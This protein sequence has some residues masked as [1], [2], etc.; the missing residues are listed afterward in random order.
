MDCIFCRII[1][2]EIPATVVYRD[3]DV[4]AFNDISPAAP[5]HVLI[6]P[7]K[8]IPRIS[9]IEDADA[10]L[11]GKMHLVAK[12]IAAEAGL[13]DYRLLINCGEKVGQT[14]FHIH[15]HLLGGERDSWPPL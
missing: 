12:K 9:D 8:H 7:V 11:L 10:E 14:V 1:S 6:I 4:V 2:E 13:E 5:T 15:M 3:K